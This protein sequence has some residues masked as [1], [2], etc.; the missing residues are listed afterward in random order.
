MTTY[1]KERETALEAIKHAS[2][3]CISI[4]HELVSDDSVSKD[5]RSP[6]T[7]ADF[8]AQAVVNLT[9]EKYFPNDVI[10]GEEDASLLRADD[11][12]EL[13][14][15]VTQHVQSILPGVSEDEVLSAI[16]RG[17]H[18]GGAKGRFWVLDPIDGTKGFL[19]GEQYAVAL[20]LIEDGDVKLGGLG[21]PNLPHNLEKPD[22][23]AGCIFISIKDQGAFQLPI[24]G[25]TEEQIHTS[26]CTDL[27]EARFCE[28][29]ESGHSSQSTT[30]KIAESLGITRDPFRMDS[31]CKYASVAKGLAEIY[32]RLPVKKD[33]KEKIWDHAA[34][35]L[36]VI[37]AGGCVTDISGKAIDFTK[38]RTLDDNE[39]IIATTIPLQSMILK[40]ARDNIPPPA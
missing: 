16:D 5:D 9:L 4:Q 3:L 35:W 15:K 34:G 10:V 1:S 40:A 21:C 38:G 19:R 30:S 28:S 37:E 11:G 31:Q 36:L 39:G 27:K 26:P 33:Y 2:K 32:L 25:G 18:G 13:R 29:V 23:P 6:V 24:N 22:G 17:N 20:A 8:G 14:N 12:E 7:I